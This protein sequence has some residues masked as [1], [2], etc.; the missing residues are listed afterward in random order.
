[1]KSKKEDLSSMLYAASKRGRSGMA[2]LLG[3]LELPNVCALQKRV[4]KQFYSLE[5]LDERRSYVDNIVLADNLP[6]CVEINRIILN[7]YTFDQY[8]KN[9]RYFQERDKSRRVWNIYQNFLEC[10]EELRKKISR[11]GDINEKHR[12][13]L[14]VVSM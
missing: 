13:S 3:R 14:N 6:I 11:I 8:A 4:I 7:S 1:M 9:S 12:N 5:T 2:N 10:S